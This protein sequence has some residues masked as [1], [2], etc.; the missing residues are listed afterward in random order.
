MKRRS[1]AEK[2]GEEGLLRMCLQFEEWGPGIEDYVI[3]YKNSPPGERGQ[4][5]EKLLVIS[6]FEAK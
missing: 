4:S 3:D 5:R 2:I 1:S 6:I